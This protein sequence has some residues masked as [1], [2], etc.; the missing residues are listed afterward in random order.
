MNILQ[1]SRSEIDYGRKLM[2]SAVEG[3]RHGE[4]DYLKNESRGHYLEKAALHAVVPTILGACLGGLGG[5]L[6]KRRSTGKVLACA[7]L[8]GAIGFGASVAWENR[9]L[10]ASVATAAWKGINK[11][12]DAH[13]FE[14]NPIDY[15]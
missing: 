3:A 5:Y 8:G 11:T 14:R 6:E 1:W 10:T 13:W 7:F 15:A 9:K 12:R 4:G 2:D